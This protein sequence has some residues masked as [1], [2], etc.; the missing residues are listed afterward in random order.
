MALS[1]LRV[2]SAYLLTFEDFEA[3]IY[4]TLNLKNCVSTTNVY[5][6]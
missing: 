4:G 1:T 6:A 3:R 5:R 2:E